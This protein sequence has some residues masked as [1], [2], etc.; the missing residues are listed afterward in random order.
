MSPEGRGAAREETRRLPGLAAKP[1]SFSTMLL[2]P[3]QSMQVREDRLPRAPPSGSLEAARLRRLPPHER[4]PICP[5]QAQA[6]SARPTSDFYCAASSFSCPLALIFFVFESFEEP[7]AAVRPKE[8]LRD[9]PAHPRCRFSR[10][11][12]RPLRFRPAQGSRLRASPRSWGRSRHPR[13]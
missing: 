13:R 3:P 7:L 10:R 12:C 5:R 11:V 1:T 4:P 8:A 9:P 2:G 6:H